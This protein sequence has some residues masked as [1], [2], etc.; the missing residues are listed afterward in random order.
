M[1]TPASVAKHPIHPML[2][3]VPMGLWIFS[4]AADFI[5]LAAG[6]TRWRDVAFYTMAG[7]VIGALIAAIPGLV[8]FFS[9]A[10]AKVKKIALYHMVINLTIVALYAVNLYLRYGGADGALPIVLSVLGVA[11]L[12][13]AGWFGGELV[14]VHGMGVQPSENRSADV[15]R[16]NAKK[17]RTIG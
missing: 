5:G 13:V 11:L 6:A 10:D 9:I 14:Y 12:A 17:I 15:R 8:D 1:S 7:G 2:V 4:L 3:V 16:I